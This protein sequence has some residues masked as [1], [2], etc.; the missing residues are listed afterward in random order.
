Y[1]EGLL[2]NCWNRTSASPGSC[3]R[4]AGGTMLRDF[5]WPFQLNQYELPFVTTSKRMAWGM[6][7]GAVGQ[8]SYSSFG[9]SLVGYPYQSY[10][11][12]LVLGNRS[13]HLTDAQSAEV[14]AA[15]GASLTASVGTVA[16][17]GPGGAGRSDNVPYSPAGYDPVYGTWVI[18]ASSGSA[19]FR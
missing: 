14:A 8:R 3:L 2:A 12:Y 6:S 9:R 19:A 10:S 7:R 5:L 18:S 16:T 13:D 15:A 1:G 17:S 11:V 4:Q